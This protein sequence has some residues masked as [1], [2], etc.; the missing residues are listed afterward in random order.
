MLTRRPAAERGSTKL[1]WLDS[2]HT[3]SFGAAHDPGWMGFGPLRVI[4]DDRVA[5]GAGFPTHPHRDME[6]ITVPLAGELEHKDSTGGGGVIRPGDVQAMSAGTGVR[7]S[8]FNHSKSEP[9]HL[10]QVWIEP[11][12][13]GV[14][15]RYAQE[16]F[17]LP[18]GRLIAVASGDGREGSLAIHQDATLLLGRLEGGQRVRRDLAAGRRAWVHVATGA[19]RVN[20]EAL[21]EG[22]GLGLTDEAAVEVEG[23]AQGAMVLVFD[24]P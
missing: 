23:V 2:R 21:R 3:F 14:E 22:D 10:L 7:H 4:N 17:E 11:A 24:L 12:Q 19:A 16:R 5:P 9:V 13:R 18:P 6:I 1:D 8:E 20:G 15:P